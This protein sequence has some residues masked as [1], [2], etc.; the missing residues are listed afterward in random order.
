MLTL[1]TSNHSITRSLILRI[2]RI[3]VI[4]GN[5]R[6]L[7]TPRRHNLTITMRMILPGNTSRLTTAIDKP[8]RSQKLTKRTVLTPSRNTSISAQ[9]SSHNNG[10]QQGATG[11]VVDD[12]NGGASCGVIEDYLH[13][14]ICKVR[15]ELGRDERGGAAAYSG[16]LKNGYIKTPCTHTVHR[17]SNYINLTL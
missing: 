15:D 4:P 13:G 17:A 5:L 14:L 2:Q 11:L 16:K 10:H 12:L 8:S 3:R 9:F 6:S 7:L 1:L